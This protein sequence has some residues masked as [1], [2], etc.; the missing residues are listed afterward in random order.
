VGCDL[1][2][3]IIKET[4]AADLVPHDVPKSGARFEVF[5]AMKVQVMVVTLKME[6][7]RSSETFVSYH[8]TTRCHNTEDHD[9]NYSS[10]YLFR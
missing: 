10:R 8:V 9:L 6:A 7:A 5:T 1:F 4:Q 3:E 2:Q